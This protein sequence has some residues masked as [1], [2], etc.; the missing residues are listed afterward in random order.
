MIS[1]I[2][3][4]QIVTILG[5]THE[6]ENQLST[7]MDGSDSCG[8]K[9]RFLV[10]NLGTEDETFILW[11]VWGNCRCQMSQL[12]VEL[13]VRGSWMLIVSVKEAQTPSLDWLGSTFDSAWCKCICVSLTHQTK[14]LF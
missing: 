12:S 3:C 6:T 4:G 1:C 10:I 9:Y 13:R 11:Y 14:E 8:F 7:R 5:Y 2:H